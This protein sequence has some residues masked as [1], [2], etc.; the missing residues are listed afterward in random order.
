[1]YY[2]S[3]EVI[4]KMTWNILLNVFHKISWKKIRRHFL[5]EEESMY[6]DARQWKDILTCRT[7]PTD[8]PD[9]TD[10]PSVAHPC[11]TGYRQFDFMA[12][13][14]DWWD[15]NSYHKTTAFHCTSETNIHA[16]QSEHTAR[17]QQT[18]W[19]R[20]SGISADFNLWGSRLLIYLT[21]LSVAKVI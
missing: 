7:K 8:G 3:R 16:K 21:T 9:A 18:C 4:R 6:V 15:A 20:V 1:M 2:V 14:L 19:S 5:N 12:S 17:C 11:P 10:V 13:R